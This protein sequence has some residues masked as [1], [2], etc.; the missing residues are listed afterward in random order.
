MIGSRKYYLINTQDESH[1]M[2]NS[3]KISIAAAVLMSMNVMIGTGILFGPQLMAAN[4]GS[5]S[6]LGWT[7]GALLLCPIIINVADAARMFPGEGGFFSYCRST[8]GETGA[9]MATW[10]FFLGYVGT[11]AVQTSVIR[12][13]LI[14]SFNCGWIQTNPVIFYLISVITFSLLNLLSIT[15]ISR[16]QSSVTIIKLIPLFFV[17][18]LLGGYYNPNFHLEYARVLKL[19]LVIPT[20]IFAFNGWEACC[21]IGHLIQ[22]GSKKVPF[23]IFSAFGIV[24]LLY[25]IF[26]LSILHIMGVDNL[27]KFGAASFPLFLGFSA[28]TVNMLNIA[29]AYAFMISYINSL[30]GVYVANVTTLHSLAHKDLIFFSKR[31]SQ[32]NNLERPVAVIGIYGI[33]ALTLS[34]LIADTTILIGITGLGVI[35]SFFT[36]ML[37]LAVAFYQR[38]NYLK[39]VQVFFGFTS[40]SLL[41]YLSFMST[42]A[43]MKIRLLK[44]LPLLFGYIVGYVMLHFKQKEKAQKQLDQML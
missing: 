7:I 16:I 25:T 10:S 37:S 42:G 34:C 17:I 15:V 23:V 33:I 2:E 41:L 14:R 21:S 32:V 27:I 19:G 39:L 28:Q 24:V 12:D 5:F 4:A 3:G 11:T 26:H 35:S 40:C 20:S 13:E 6:F 22:G 9:F 31:L 29:I 8:L 30:Y 18:F 36:T 43:T 1:I 38:K 44:I